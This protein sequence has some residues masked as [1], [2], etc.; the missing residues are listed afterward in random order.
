VRQSPERSGIGPAGA[1]RIID[2]DSSSLLPVP[3][4]SMVNRLK[5][6]LAIG[7]SG[8]A[9]AGF[10]QGGAE[11]FALSLRFAG[12]LFGPQDLFRAQLLLAVQTVL[13]LDAAASVPWILDAYLGPDVFDKHLMIGNLVAVN[14]LVGGML[15]AMLA[16][17]LWAVFRLRRISLEVR[18]LW[19][20]Y[21]SV[22]ICL[23][24]CANGIVWLKR[25]GVFSSTL[26]G[27]I[28]VVS[29][30]LNAALMVGPVYRFACR[31]LD[32]YWT[33]PARSDSAAFSAPGRAL[34]LALGGLWV[35]TT[36][37]LNML[38][39]GPAQHGIVTPSHRTEV[40]GRPSVAA[41]PAREGKRPNVILISIDSLRADHLSSYGYE[42]PTSPE[43][44]AL[45]DEGVLFSQAMSTTSWT[46]PSH[47]SMLTSMHAE[48]HGVIAARDHLDD[49]IV[50]L[51]ELLQ[52]EGYATAAFVSAPFLSSRYG[53]SQGFDLYD[54]FTVDFASHEAS[55]QGLTS[56]QITRQTLRWLDEHGHRDFFLFMHYWDVHYDYAPPPPYDTMFDRDYAGSLTAHSFETNRR[57]NPR[58][59]DVDLNHVIA[60]YDGEIAYT[61]LHVGKLIAALKERGLFDD[62]LI[63]VTADHGDEFFEHGWKGH[64]HTLYEELLR[65]PLIFKFPGSWGG[66]QQID[67]VVSIIDI[68]PTILDSLG[69]EYGD[70]MQGRSLLPLLSGGESP[71]DSFVYA[72]LTSKLV[73]VRSDHAK[74]IHTLGNG[75]GRQFYDLKRDPEEKRNLVR[76]GERSSEEERHLRSLLDWLNVQRQSGRLIR[77]SEAGQ[78]TELNEPLM[79]E[80]RSLGYIE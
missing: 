30:A 51:A 41:V 11:A 48:S 32:R 79:E 47:V 58:M 7:V 22:V 1:G 67:D 20:F 10:I 77:Q 24:V 59:S 3:E 42:R 4:G 21:V 74:F 76:S 36:L 54:D 40:R 2:V 26:L 71:A 15:G 38:S 34:V 25:E 5:T 61:D 28:V 52:A 31:V 66:P 56:P 55:H 17:S 19:V 18:R 8:G 80:L 13:G 65:V 33:T 64:M 70:E 12:F 45:A 78:Q 44:D 69:I 35:V 73:A 49:R 6:H 27:S 63:V 75:P 29:L 46:L 43:I 9:I 39:R 50:T 60:L 23:G 62:T 57:I 72:R 16:V 37:T 68:A 14:T 53:F